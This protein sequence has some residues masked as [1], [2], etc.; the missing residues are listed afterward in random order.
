LALIHFRILYLDDAGHFRA[1]QTAF[2]VGRPARPIPG[3][4]HVFVPA[5]GKRG[6]LQAER[7]A[8]E[9]EKRDVLEL[10][11]RHLFPEGGG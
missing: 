10:L 5:P 3:E 8:T 2:G 6:S 1:I 11:R 7:A 4:A 9:Q